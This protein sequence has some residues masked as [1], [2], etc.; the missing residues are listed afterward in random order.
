MAELNRI[1]RDTRRILT[2]LFDERNKLLVLAQ[3]KDGTFV[4]S[5][6]CREAEELQRKRSR[7]ESHPRGS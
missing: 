2:Q 5:H 7:A 3:G 1:Q 4:G 6:C